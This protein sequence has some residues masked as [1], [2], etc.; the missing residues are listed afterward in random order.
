MPRLASGGAAPEFVFVIRRLKP[1]FKHP[2]SAID[3]PGVMNPMP[4]VGYHHAIARK[5]A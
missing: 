1:C 2:V 4:A 3:P 5:I